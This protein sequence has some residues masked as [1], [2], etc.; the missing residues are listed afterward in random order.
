MTPANVVAFLDFREAIK[1]IRT[2]P[3]PQ[4]VH[5]LKY[6]LFTAFERAADFQQ[7]AI[8]AERNLEQYAAIVREHHAVAAEASPE[9]EAAQAHQDSDALQ[10]RSEVQSLLEQRETLSELCTSLVQ[11]IEHYAC[12]EVDPED[13]DADAH[14]L[15]LPLPLPIAAAPQ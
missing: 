2:L 15:P 8:T 12:D 14:T 10:L 7:R 11:V 1:E 5:A 4:Q 6:K 3:E 13:Q 9:P